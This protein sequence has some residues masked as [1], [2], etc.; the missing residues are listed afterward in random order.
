MAPRPV[1]K[2]YCPDSSELR[3]GV[4]DGAV[5]N[6]LRKITPSRA[7]RSQFGVLI[8]SF[9]EDRPS[10]FAYALACRPQSSANTKRMFGREA[11][12]AWSAAL[13]GASEK[14]RKS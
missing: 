12:A 2:K 10:T 1:R 11:S 9:M 7:T 5:T 14:T 3:H 8:T 4:Q 13:K 6:A